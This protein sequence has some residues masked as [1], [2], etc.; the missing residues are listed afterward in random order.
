MSGQTNSATVDPVFRDYRF[1]KERLVSIYDQP[2]GR[3]QLKVFMGEWLKQEAPP[4]GDWVAVKFRGGRGF[5]K[6]AHLG[7]QRLLEIFFIDV[8]QGDSILIQTPKDRRILIDGGQTKDALSFVEN[9]Y[10]LDKEDNYIDFEAV[11]ASHSDQDHTQGLIALLRHPKI[12]V[13]RVY[14]NGLFRRAKG[15]DPGP[16][17]HARVSGLVDTLPTDNEKANLTPLMKDFVAAIERDSLPAKIKAMKAYS[18]WQTG[19]TFTPA[20]FVARDW[21]PRWVSCR[22]STRPI[23]DCPFRSYGRRRRRPVGCPVSPGMAM[24]ARRSTATRICPEVDQL[25]EQ[26][27]C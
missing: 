26:P 3:E 23:R 12:L 19:L 7:T 17:Q 21:M 8:D 2:E 18:R 1:A 6:T 16:R 15:P 24:W 22:R 14:H 25:A 5:V 4:V 20:D 10:R 9:K 11:V 27:S 13:K